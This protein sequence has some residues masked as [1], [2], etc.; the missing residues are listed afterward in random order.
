MNPLTVLTRFE[1][2]AKAG[3]KTVDTDI[4]QGL[5]GE[6]AGLAVKTRSQTAKTIEFVPSSGYTDPSNPDW[7]KIHAAVQKALG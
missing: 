1:R 5:L 7:A 4:P 6:F 3:S 2:I